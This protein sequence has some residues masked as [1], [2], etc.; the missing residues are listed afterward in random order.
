MI[1]CSGYYITRPPCHH[2]SGLPPLLGMANTQNLAT[3][4]KK[5]FCR[6]GLPSLSHTQALTP[7]TLRPLLI[8]IN[9]KLYI[10]KI[11]QVMIYCHQGQYVT[12]LNKYFQSSKQAWFMGNQFVENVPPAGS[13]EICCTYLTPSK[14]CQLLNQ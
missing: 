10:M 13:F 7:P 3:Q 9:L 4:N 2:P 5:N 1:S 14:V 11:Y 6:E 12:S 8:N